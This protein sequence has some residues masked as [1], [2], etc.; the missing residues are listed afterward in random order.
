MWPIDTLDLHT[1]LYDELVLVSN[2]ANFCFALL[3]QLL[4]IVDASAQAAFRMARNL[5]ST[6]ILH[7]CNPHYHARP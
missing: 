2:S 4:A 1:E 3:A 7:G 5:Y 6:L